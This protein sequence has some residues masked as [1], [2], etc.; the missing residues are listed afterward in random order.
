[1]IYMPCSGINAEYLSLIFILSFFVVFLC[2]SPL[3]DGTRWPL[4]GSARGDFVL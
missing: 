2:P 3:C 1:M 4:L